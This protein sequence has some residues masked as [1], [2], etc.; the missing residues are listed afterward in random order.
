M[1]AT[2]R[3]ESGTR[4]RARLHGGTPSDVGPADGGERLPHRADEPVVRA[5]RERRPPGGDVAGRVLELAERPR[6]EPRPARRKPLLQ[7]SPSRGGD[8]RAVPLEEQVAERVEGEVGGRG[9]SPEPRRDVLGEPAARLGLSAEA[10]PVHP[11]PP[12]RL[13]AYARSCGRGP[14]H[15]LVDRAKTE[16]TAIRTRPIP[17]NVQSYTS[18]FETPSR[19]WWAP[20]AR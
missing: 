10:A 14:C 16:P 6:A 18:G 11:A 9:S 2:A 13:H 4:R 15:G 8:G 3:A 20:S 1:A 12:A 19:T 7:R 17:K 5:R